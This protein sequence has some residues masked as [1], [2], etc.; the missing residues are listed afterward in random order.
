[1]GGIE[2]D[3]AERVERGAKWMRETYG[4]NWWAGMDWERFNIDDVGNCLMGQMH[5]SYHRW[6]G[7]RG[8]PMSTKHGFTSV[9]AFAAAYGL[10]ARCPFNHNSLDCLCEEMAEALNDEWRRVAAALNG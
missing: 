3:A 4:A 8:G 5:G 9:G 10:L 2:E 6:V 1:M 7:T